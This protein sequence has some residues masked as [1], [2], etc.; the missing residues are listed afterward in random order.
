MWCFKSAYV[1]LDVSTFTP[2]PAHCISPSRKCTQLILE[3]R[4]STRLFLSLFCLVFITL[5]SLPATCLCSDHTF[6]HFLVSHAR[7][8]EYVSY[9]AQRFIR[10]VSCFTAFQLCTVLYPTS[11]AQQRETYHPHQ[12]S[13]RSFSSKSHQTYCVRVLSCS[14]FR[15][16]RVLF[17]CLPTVRSSL[18]NFACS[19][20]R[21]IPSPPKKPCV[22]EFQT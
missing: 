1:R 18:S 9:L 4:A 22:S 12:K 14:T 7:H 21:G 5:N 6:V 3:Y 19:A 10:N 20:T 17:Y 15:Q 8:I 13:P 2:P 16:E 11:P